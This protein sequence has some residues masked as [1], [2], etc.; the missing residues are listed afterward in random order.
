MTETP[1]ATVATPV[2]AVPDVLPLAL[3]RPVLRLAA[4]GRQLAPRKRRD[5]Q[6]IA[7]DD[8]PPPSRPIAAD[9]DR[10]AACGQWAAEVVAVVKAAPDGIEAEA[11]ADALGIPE[12][13]ARR[14]LA[15]TAARGITTTTAAP[16]TGRH[17]PRNVYR[18]A[19]ADD[20]LAAERAVGA[21]VYVRAVAA[22][23]ARAERLAAARAEA[24]TTGEPFAVVLA[25]MR[26]DDSRRA[27]A[28]RR[29][30]AG[31]EMGLEADRLERWA[32]QTPIAAASL[33][34]PIATPSTGQVV[35]MALPT[36]LDA[37]GKERIQR[38]AADRARGERPNASRVE[39]SGLAL[40][41]CAACVRTVQDAAALPDAAERGQLAA[42]A[43]PPA[44][45]PALPQTP[46]RRYGRGS[47]IDLERDHAHAMAAAL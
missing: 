18:Y 41:Y 29:A 16:S 36:V 1:A 34:V 19:P 27:A 33:I 5:V 21:R 40:H 43:S 13:A 35:Y 45:A 26:V 46:T 37:A 20:A 10:L 30:A 22:A 28:Q 24:N 31:G 4:G 17:R 2:G 39:W 8:L 14:T 25:R 12:R 32:A 11:V 9:V 38:A 3:R 47:F 23:E 42:P 7:A 15:A 44:A 6:V